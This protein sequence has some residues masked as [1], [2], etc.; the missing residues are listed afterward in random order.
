MVTRLGLFCSLARESVRVE[1]QA[2]EGQLAALLAW[3][4][5]GRQFGH[6]CGLEAALAQFVYFLG[7]GAFARP[8]LLVLGVIP[9]AHAPHRDDRTDCRVATGRQLTIWKRRA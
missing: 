4:A 2:A 3:V 9:D 7:V 8:F 6:T 5:L 1:V